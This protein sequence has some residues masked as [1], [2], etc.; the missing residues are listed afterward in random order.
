MVA[1]T[2]AAMVAV[3]A[4]VVMEVEGMEVAGKEEAAK[5]VALMEAETVEAETVEAELGEAAPAVVEM[6][7]AGVVVG[8]MV[9]V[10]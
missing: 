9:E 10:D 8:V 1:A 7:T 5:G 6:A 3:V 2:V 4:G